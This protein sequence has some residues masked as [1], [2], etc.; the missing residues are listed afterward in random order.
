MGSLE[1]SYRSDYFSR[2]E[3][4]SLPEKAGT[5]SAATKSARNLATGPARKPQSSIRIIIPLAAS[6]RHGGRVSARLWPSLSL[7]DCVIDAPPGRLACKLIIGIYVSRECL[8]RRG[9]HRN[10]ALRSYV[11]LILEVERCEPRNAVADRQSR[12][13]REIW[14]SRSRG[15]NVLSKTTNVC[16]IVESRRRWRDPAA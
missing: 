2:H 7:P 8:A 11:S 9:L 1:P 10:V 14:A 13:H 16:S 15:A 6:A 5:R 12:C 4:S 3:T